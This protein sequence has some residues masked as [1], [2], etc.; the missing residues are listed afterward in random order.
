MQDIGLLGLSIIHFNARSLNA[1]FVKIYDYL[2]GLSL[3][4]DIIAIS[5]TW[6]QSD[7][8]T[9][10]Q[11]NGYELFSVR[12]KTKGGGGVVLYVKQDIQCQLLTEKSVSIEGILEC[13]TVA[14]QVNKPI[15]KKCV[16]SCIYRTPGSN[17]DMF[18]YTINSIFS[19]SKYNSSL[20]VCGDFN[21]DL[22]KNGEHVGTTKFIDAMYSIGLYP[23]I[24]KPSRITQYSATL[25]DNIF[26]NELTNQ[27]IS[28]LLINDISDHLPIFS[29]TRSSPKRLNSLKY[30]TIRKSSKESV[31]AFIEDLNRQTWHNTYKSDDANIAYDNF[32]DTFIKLYNKHCPLKRVINKNLNTNNKPWFTN[33]LRNACLKK[34]LLYKEFLKKRTLTVQSRYKSYKNKLTN[35]LRKSEKM[36]YNQLL[37]EQRDNIKS[38][39]QTLN[40]LIKKSKQS[41]T[42]PESFDDNGKCVSDKNVAV[43]KFNQYFVNVGV[44]LANKIPVPKQNK[45]CHDYMPK[46]NECNLFLSPV[47]QEDIITTVNNC[48]SKTSCDHNN[49]DMVIIKQVINYIAKP[50]AHVC[51]T[52]F[53]HG[54]FPD[55]MKVAKVVPLFKAGDRSV[56]SNYRPISLLSQ[57]S[58]I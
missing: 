49:I 19:D 33:G 31:D 37:H 44:D 36:Y 1:N 13:V 2:N 8:I 29:L 56:F 40:A 53:E 9:E 11:I 48:K 10:F 17:I 6:I 23:L 45:S 30:K 54:V 41:S 39:W 26:T 27:I 34:N 18:I 55:N 3:N 16:I 14:I 12:R 52:S 50:L 47:L 57:F 38:T 32:L 5:E 28:G 58:K 35:I 46:T 43:N 25:I 22:L 20:F 7:S 4:F 24:D 42:Y 15:S 51:S 21:I